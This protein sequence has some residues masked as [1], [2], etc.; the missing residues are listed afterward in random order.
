MLQACWYYVE[1][2]IRARYYVSVPDTVQISRSPSSV[3]ALYLTSYV[4]SVGSELALGTSNFKYCTPYLS[5]LDFINIKA[6][7]LM[8]SL[9]LSIV[10]VPTSSKYLHKY[11]LLRYTCTTYVVSKLPPTCTSQRTLATS[12]YLLR[13][14][15]VQV[16][17][18]LR[19]T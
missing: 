2:K 11:V 14:K 5:L 16:L 12:G 6:R 1:V 19:T 8:R 13:T 7:G 4:D 9:P 17:R 15:Y 10:R 3:E 18:V